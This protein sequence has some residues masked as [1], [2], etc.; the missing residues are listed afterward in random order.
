M[1]PSA[2]DQQQLR[3][4][5]ETLAAIS[6][7]RDALE[8]FSDEVQPSDRHVTHLRGWRNMVENLESFVRLDIAADRV[9]RQSRR[10]EAA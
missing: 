3:E 1:P 6:R 2:A 9:A 5:A 10:A 4:I 8:L 7:L